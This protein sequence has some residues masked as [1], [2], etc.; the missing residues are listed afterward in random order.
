[1]RAPTLLNKNTDYDPSKMGLADLPADIL[2]CIFT[3]IEPDQL[4]P[5]WVI[6]SKFASILNE[7]RLWIFYVSRDYQPEEFPEKRKEIEAY[8]HENHTSWKNY[9][10]DQNSWAWSKTIKAEAILLSKKYKTASRPTGE[11]SNPVVLT[12]KPFAPGRN[13]ISVK[14][15]HVGNWIG[16][17]FCDE[18]IVLNNDS[19]LG[20]QSQ[21]LNSSFFHQSGTSL[22]LVYPPS[23]QV[24]PTSQELP[25]T[26]P[27]VSGDVV[28]LEV[29]F[30][31]V[32]VSYFLNE[33]FI[34]K[35]DLTPIEKELRKGKI[36]P[37]VNISQSTVVSLI[38][39]RKN[40]RAP[41]HPPSLAKRIVA[42]VTSNRS[43]SSS[44][45]SGTTTPTDTNANPPPAT[46]TNATANTGT[47]NNS[48]AP[49]RRHTIA[50]FTKKDKKCSIM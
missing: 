7:D 19:V 46:P 4:Q 17:G 23:A 2:F 24:T 3:F 45:S 31:Q 39:T 40:L 28:A 5:L 12:T 29:D 22:R 36:F 47:N 50:G 25:V 37:A 8:L 15:E 33:K 9:Y 16:I 14:A 43:S 11:G 48:T 18:N 35:F 27:I 1:M 41:D 30:T 21:R 20:S 34:G 49:K 13:K 6:C 26:D 38:P 44:S 42:A 10:K 32:S